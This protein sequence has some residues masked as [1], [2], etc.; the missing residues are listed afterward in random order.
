MN[1]VNIFLNKRDKIN[2]CR[3][4]QK[5]IIG[6]ERGVEVCEECIENM[7]GVEELMLKNA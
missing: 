6:K 4:H 3:I 7:L 5:P 1:R 2:K